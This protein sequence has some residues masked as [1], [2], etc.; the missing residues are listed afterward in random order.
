[1]LIFGGDKYK[2]RC[3]GTIKKVIALFEYVDEL[4]QIHKET[5]RPGKH[6]KHKQ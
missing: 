3:T 5:S 2:Y 1:L 4:N 6:F